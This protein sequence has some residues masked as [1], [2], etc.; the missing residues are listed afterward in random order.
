MKI[1]LV[2]VLIILFWTTIFLMSL[3][4]PTTNAKI[5]SNISELECF[6]MNCSYQ[7]RSSNESIC[8]CLIK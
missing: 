3:K 4:Y 6:K 7:P 8:V 5:I 1:L 2:G